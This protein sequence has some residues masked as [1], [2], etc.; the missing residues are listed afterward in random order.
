MRKGTYGPRLGR[1]GA[2]IFLALTQLLPLL[3]A[4]SLTNVAIVLPDSRSD[5]AAIFDGDRNYLFG[6]IAEGSAP[7]R[8]DI[9]SQDPESGALIRLREKLP[10]ARYAFPAV[11]TGSAAYLF[12]GRQWSSTDEDLDQILRFDPSTGTVTVAGARLPSPRADTSAVW[13][14]EFAFIFGGKR[15]GSEL[16][17]IVRYDPAT[18]S[19]VVLH[20]RLPS[21]RSQTTAVWS[22][23]YVYVLGGGCP[24]YCDEIVRFDP[25]TEEVRVLSTRLPEPRSRASAVWTG[26]FVV[27]FGGDT[28]SGRSNEIVQFDPATDV[29]AKS[30]AELPNRSG[31]TAATWDGEVAWLFGGMHQSSGVFRYHPLTQSLH[32]VGLRYPMTSQGAVWAGDATYLF[33]TSAGLALDADREIQRY[34]QGD[35][36]PVALGTRL[37]L[38]MRNFLSVWV[39]EAALLIGGER[40]DPGRGTIGTIL[41]FD[42]RT[43][44]LTALPS[45]IPARRAMSGVWTGTE[46][47]VFGGDLVEGATFRPVYTN[48]ILRV[49]PRTGGTV[50]A[51]AKLPTPRAFTSAAWDGRYAYVFGGYNGGV[52]GDVLRY[53]PRADTIEVL[54]AVLGSGRAYTTAISTGRFAYL[55]GGWDGVAHTTQIQRFDAERG[56]ISVMSARLPDPRIGIAAVW[57]GKEALLFGGSGSL[58]GK[59]APL[60]I[61]RYQLPPG[62]PT[63]LAATRGPGVG[64]VTLTWSPPAEATLHG[65]VTGYRVYRG[66]SPTETHY[67]GEATGTRFIDSGLGDGARMYYRVTAVSDTGESASSA[68]AATRAPSVPGPPFGISPSILPNAG[69]VVLF[70]YAPQEDGGVPIE[71]Y[72]I[73]RATAGAIHVP[74]GSVSGTTWFVD[75]LP[76]AGAY[77][78]R[79]TA[80]NAVGE[81][82]FSDDGEALVGPS[83]DAD[84]AS[85]PVAF[86]PDVPEVPEFEF[87][88]D[89]IRAI[90]RPFVPAVVG[91]FT[92]EV[93]GNAVGARNISADVYVSPVAGNP[94]K[95]GERRFVGLGVGGFGVGIEIAAAPVGILHVHLDLRRSARGGS[96][97]TFES[98]DACLVNEVDLEGTVGVADGDLQIRS[99]NISRGEPIFEPS[100]PFSVVLPLREP[101]SADEK[102]IPIRVSLG[103][104]CARDLRMNLTAPPGVFDAVEGHHENISI[105]LD[106]APARLSLRSLNRTTRADPFGGTRVEIVHDGSLLNGT[107]RI[108]NEQ[109]IA[110]RAIPREFTVD[111]RRQPFEEDVSA[112]S[113]GSDLRRLAIE[114]SGAPAGGTEIDYRATLEHMDAE[115][116]A[117]RLVSGA[118]VIDDDRESLAADLAFESRLGGSVEGRIKCRNDRE[119]LDIEVRARGVRHALVEARSDAKR[120]V[121]GANLTIGGSLEVGGVWSYS[122][123]L[124][125]FS[126]SLSRERLMGIPVYRA[127][128]E[129]LEI[130]TFDEIMMA[131]TETTTSLGPFDVLF[132]AARAA[133]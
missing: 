22:G 37:P 126:L 8:D 40:G 45:G 90:G 43:E 105:V 2:A 117:K 76:V 121:L 27:L 133:R 59:G 36:S 107:L 96:A 66:P 65:P 18:D 128:A 46:V 67:M 74:V 39:G 4:D 12:G 118:L 58:P 78:Y 108:G 124:L 115:I 97:A 34:S 60:D 19:A 106:G 112:C 26:T 86:L 103:G 129:V 20:A 92:F 42:P 63:A 84:V 16:D 120:Y 3:E 77:E 110:V 21:G 101:A 28:P 93:V 56:T 53:D 9:Y 17:E 94:M 52:L 38:A 122:I 41:R 80:V 91:D 57:T 116:S 104:I 85:N 31:G 130:Q 10:S 71:R 70:W 88:A 131:G 114:V 5:A 127:T 100:N 7:A 14:G 72:M 15:G 11:W 44:T 55:F 79:V 13:T 51:S 132:Q 29:V 33:G 32:V 61:L 50:V 47:L 119:G 64:E 35:L 109:V 73:Y 49:D 113:D 23:Q 54:P 95:P 68:F 83:P 89:G 24:W 62:A 48:D 81:G 69:G 75:Q 123:P 99:L 87:Y 111:L 98:D 102:E 82:E 25:T 6:G 125:P 30:P 1:K